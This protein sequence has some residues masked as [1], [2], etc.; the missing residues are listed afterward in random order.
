[1][2]KSL[3]DERGFILIM[4]YGLISALAIFSLALFSRNT[5]FL[6]STERNQNKVVAFNMAEAGVDMAITQLATDTTYEGAA[7]SSMTSGPMQGGYDVTVTT[8]DNAPNT[9][10]IVARG[11]APDNVSTSR[12]YETRNITVYAEIGTQN[13]FDFAVFADQ[14]LQLTGNATVDSYN[15]TVGAYGGANKASN[16]DVGTNST[17][18]ST[19][20]LNGNATIKGDA[21]VGPNGN[22]ASVISLTGNAAITGVKSAAPALKDFP[23]QSSNS[24]S[25]G[26]LTLSGNTTRVIG[27]GTYRFSSIS[28]TGNATLQATGPVDIYV[29]G[30]VKIAGN[31][32]STQANTPPNFLLFVTTADDV[33]LSGNG[34][35]YG[36]IYAPLSH[37]KNTGNG[38]LY[39]AVVSD[40]Y[41][42]TGNGNVHYDEAMRDAGGVGSNGVSLVS[43]REENTAA[44][45]TTSSS[46]S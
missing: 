1:M 7:Y 34:N 33:Q 5:S 15:S 41:Q 11:Y 40:T 32:I 26:A 46:G 35:F 19:V 12:A 8:P 4:A 29:D 25:L 24:A 20:T 3:K 44:W 43:W 9:R 16:G 18:S 31:G 36:G 28:I 22:P 21:Q 14:S 2:I 45:Q 37:V 30:P 10:L 23:T 39:G 38:E 13:M 17:G 42:Q 27:A 6:N